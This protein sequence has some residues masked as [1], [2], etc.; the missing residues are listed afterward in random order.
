MTERGWSW[1]VLAYLS[2]QVVALPTVAVLADAYDGDVRWRYFLVL[3]G[4]Q[5]ASTVLALVLAAMGAQRLGAHHKRLTTTIK[6]VAG[7]HVVAYGCLL[8]GIAA[9]VIPGDWWFWWLPLLFV[10]PIPVVFLVR[11]ARNAEHL[12]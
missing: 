5:A 4:L 10:P 7:V 8:L 2:M 3:G 6:V 11:W 12:I 1:M 9:G